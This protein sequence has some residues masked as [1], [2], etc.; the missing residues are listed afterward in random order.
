[1]YSYGAN[2]GRAGSHGS[3]SRFRSQNG[4]LIVARGRQSKRARG[5]GDRRSHPAASPRRVGAPVDLR[6]AA[7]GVGRAP[8]TGLAAVHVQTWSVHDAVM[9]LAHDLG[10]HS[11]RVECKAGPEGET[12][13]ALVLPPS[14]AP[15]IRKTLPERGSVEHAVPRQPRASSSANKNGYCCPDRSVL[16]FTPAGGLDGR[17][18][19]AGGTY[20]E[21]R[22]SISSNRSVRRG[23]AVASVADELQ[24]AVPVVHKRSVSGARSIRYADTSK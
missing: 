12:I 6:Q 17:V 19:L 10:L 15:G 9:M 4:V 11:Y 8:S 18:P 21:H 22:L 7:R 23:S 3:N 14:G 5:A 13:I 2:D 16:A 20:V 1:M 24:C